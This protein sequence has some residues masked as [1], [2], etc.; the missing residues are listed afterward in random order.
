MT[1]VY[2]RT[3]QK[4]ER[5]VAHRTPLRRSITKRTVL[6]F[7]LQRQ[8]YFFFRRIHPSPAATPDATTTAAAGPV[9]PMGAV[10]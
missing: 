9:S 6:R 8:I 10:P 3:P 2:T 7:V 4:Q 1:E 5:E